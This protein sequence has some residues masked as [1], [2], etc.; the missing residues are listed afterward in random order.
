MLCNK[1]EGV[2]IKHYNDLKVVIKYSNDI[3]YVYENIE[4][5]NL[6]KECKILI[7][8][9]AMIADVLSSKNIQQIV[10]KFFIRGRKIN[11]SLVFIKKFIFLYQE[12]LHYVFYTLFYYENSQQTSSINHI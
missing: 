4:E 11:I 2:D 6:N 3:N 1:H 7:V 12:I 10:T 8:F 9:E 5:Y